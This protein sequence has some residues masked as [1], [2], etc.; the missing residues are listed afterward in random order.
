M[1]ES[2][3]VIVYISVREWGV[4]ENGCVLVCMGVCGASVLVCVRVCENVIVYVLVSVLVCGGV[5]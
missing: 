1:C 5:V 3:C 2:V 4:H